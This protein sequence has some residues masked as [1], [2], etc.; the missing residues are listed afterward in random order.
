MYVPDAPDAQWTLYGTTFNLNHG[1]QFK[2]G[3]G[4][5]GVFSPLMLGMARKQK[6]QNAIGQPFDVMMNGHWHQYIHTDSLII[7]G[8]IK[9]YD[10]FA[11]MHNFNFEPPQQA[12]FIS[13]PE[14]RQT[15]RM[16]ILCDEKSKLTKKHAHK[17]SWAE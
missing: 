3:S 14:K 12:L 11:N 13:H 6:K 5:S 4:I 9:G 16:P 17:L 1:D 15:F 8:S 10:E 2:G 7:N